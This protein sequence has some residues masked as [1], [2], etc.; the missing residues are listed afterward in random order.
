VRYKC[1]K[2]L[3]SFICVEQ[4]LRRREPDMPAPGRRG[5]A[6]QAAVFLAAGGHVSEFSGEKRAN[7]W[8][9]F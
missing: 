9:C 3:Y 4:H 2:L 8:G 6:V 5:V 7:V 1:M